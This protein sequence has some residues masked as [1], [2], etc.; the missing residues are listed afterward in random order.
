[1]ASKCK[2]QIQAVLYHNDHDSLY[3][4]LSA[5]D[6]AAHRAS[7]RFDSV[8]VLWG[9]ASAQPVYTDDDVAALRAEFVHLSGFEYRFFNENTGYGKGNNRL[10]QEADSDYLL[11]MNPEIIIG[12]NGLCDLLA[13]FADDSVGLVEARQIPVE[14]PKEYDGQTFETPWSSGACFMISTALFHAL[15]GFDTDTFFMYCEDVD[16]S[17]RIRLAGKK[18]YY[19]PLAGVYHAKYLQQSGGNQP[20]KTEVF[21]TVLAEALLAYK[22]SYPHYARERIRIAA[23]NGYPGG[24]EALAAFTALESSGKLPDMLDP[25]HQVAKIRQFAQSGGMLFARHRY[26]L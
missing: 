3:K 5:L 19:Q 18:L 26:G 4:A 12:P 9:D 17:W 15:G 25:T 7:A 13:P 22:W 24:K 20:S 11:V 14:H 23:Q 2:L 8:R 10:A 6:N 21:Y 16:L 1:M